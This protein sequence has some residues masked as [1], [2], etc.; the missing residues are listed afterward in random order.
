MAELYSLY[1]R[2][3]QENVQAKPKPCKNRFQRAITNLFKDAK[4]EA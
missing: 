2:M 3:N 1:I 4:E